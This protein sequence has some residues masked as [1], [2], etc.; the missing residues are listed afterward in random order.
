MDGIKGNFDVADGMEYR[1]SPTAEENKPPSQYVI[2]TVKTIV[3]QQQYFFEMLWAKAIPASQRIMEIEQ[4]LERQFIKTIEDPIQIQKTIQDLVRSASFEISIV[5]SKSDEFYNQIKTGIIEQLDNLST[6]KDVKIKILTPQIS[7]NVDNINKQEQITKILKQHN[8][9]NQHKIELRYLDKALQTKVTILVV[10]RKLS[11]V[12]KSDREKSEHPAVVTKNI[13]EDANYHQ[14]AGLAIYSNIE[15]TVSSLDSIFEILGRQIDLYEELRDLYKELK[16]RDEAQKDFI[17][18]AAHELRNPIQPILGI[19]EIL[20]SKAEGSENSESLAVIVRNAKKLHR[21]AEDILDV[22]R[23]EKQSLKLNREWFNLKETI[24]NVIQD[25]KNPIIGFN[26]GINIKFKPVD[27]GF[28]TVFVY[29]DRYRISQVIANLLSNAIKFTDE[30]RLITIIGTIRDTLA[31][32][33]VTDNGA[34]ISPEIFSKLFSKYTSKSY[35][36]TGLGL[37][38]SKNI[39]ESHGGKIWAE[40]NTDGKGSLPSHLVYLLMVIKLPLLS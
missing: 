28:D 23:I 36:G 8:G 26:R 18:I 29:G 19:S 20:H 32:I 3:E 13:G 2:S 31:I 14:S 15:S 17:D 6:S 9:Q 24:I 7:A 33:S 12:V 16:V 35:K 27:E 5:F 10:D 38:I 11:L 37:Y 25:S 34:G 1:A 39:V 4:G 22:T 40:N 21:L 30:N